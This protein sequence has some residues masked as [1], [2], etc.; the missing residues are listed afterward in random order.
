M[1][2]YST[3]SILVLYMRSCNNE[4]SIYLNFVLLNYLSWLQHKN[5]T[6]RTHFVDGLYM[7]ILSQ[8]N[9]YTDIH[10]S[11]PYTTVF[12]HRMYILFNNNNLI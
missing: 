11:Y 8:Q 7:I 10:I 1:G 9:Q 2:S 3:R 4:N 5:F 12:K 6:Y